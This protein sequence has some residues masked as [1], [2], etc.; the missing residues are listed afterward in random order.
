MQMNDLIK[1]IEDMSNE[2]LLESLREL[3]HRRTVIRPAREKKIK[4]AKEKGKTTRINK[5]ADLFDSLSDADKAELLK[6]LEE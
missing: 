1:P 6:A 5:V 2:E 3:R 4:K